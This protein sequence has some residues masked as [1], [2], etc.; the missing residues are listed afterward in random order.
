MVELWIYMSERASQTV[1]IINSQG[2]HA[3]P[4]D[5][6]VRTALKF[7]SSVHVVKDGERVDGKSILSI[8]TLVAEKGTQLA[9]EAEGPDAS[10]AIEAL[11]RLVEL[12]F[13]EIGSDDATRT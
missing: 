3:R 10:E 11:V 5:L 1:T 8:L 12:G 13:D 9:I 2:L 6:F 7:D 4:A